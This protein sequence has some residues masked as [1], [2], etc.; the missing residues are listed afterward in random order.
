[1]GL[2]NKLRI[3]VHRQL[4]SLL[5]TKVVNLEGSMLV[6]LLASSLEYVASMQATYSS[7]LA[8]KIMKVLKVS[9]P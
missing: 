5:T 8:G 2:V 4:A 9:G 7:E 1:M 3:K 6:S